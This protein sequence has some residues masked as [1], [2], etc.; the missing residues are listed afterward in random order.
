MD[1]TSRYFERS[2]IQFYFNWN[3]TQYTYIA[4]GHYWCTVGNIDIWIH[5]EQWYHSWLYHQ[6]Q[7]PQSDK[8][9]LYRIK[10]ILVHYCNIDVYTYI[11]WYQSSYMYLTIMKLLH[12]YWY[13]SSCFLNHVYF[14]SVLGRSGQI[15]EPKYLHD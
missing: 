8:L 4:M 10:H 12:Y 3:Q 15:W 9:V 5:H 1:H 13:N 14:F 11:Y 2:N 7:P 6:M